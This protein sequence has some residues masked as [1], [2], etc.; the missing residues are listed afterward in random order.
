MNKKPKEIAGDSS[1]NPLMDWKKTEIKWKKVEISPDDLRRFTRRSD[2]KGLCQS[3]GFILFLCATG[4]L[5]YYAFL[6]ERWAWMAVGLYVHGTFYRQFGVAIHELIHTTVFK[7]KWL[8]TFMVYLFGFLYWPLN[9]YFYRLSH[10][11][12]H[13]RYTLHQKSDGEDTPNYLEINLKW[14]VDIFLHCIHA[15]A[16]IQNSGRLL[17][18]KPTAM[19]WRGRSYS[20]DTWEQFVLREATDKQ[21]KQVHN[22][23]RFV[24]I[25]HLLF[26]AVCL[27]TGNWFLIVLIALAPFYGARFHAVYCNTYQH[28][29]CEANNPDFRLSC[30]DAILDPLSSFLYWRMEYHIEHH[31]FAS[32]PCYNLKAF[33]RFVEN[34]L[35]PRK[36]AMTRLGELHR[37]SRKKYGTW[38][39]WE[40]CFGFYKGV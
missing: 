1:W 19:G 40:K 2:F 6:Q 7:T 28:A 20:L 17:T 39:N 21:R 31:M 8:N 35:P 25:G 3:V 22:F 34:Q 38:G 9:P 11:G 32:I 30:G 4:G 18:C 10:T 37:I 14:F 29:A 26:A 24:L 36:P 16:L 15:K 5:T 33:R 13:H 12:Y 23:S 27:V